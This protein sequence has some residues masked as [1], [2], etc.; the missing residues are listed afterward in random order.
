M[1]SMRWPY[2]TVDEPL[3]PVG[4]AKIK[5]VKKSLRKLGYRPGPADGLTGRKTSKA[6]KTLQKDRGL[7]IDG[8]PS[9]SLLAVLD[10]LI[11]KKMAVSDKTTAY[12][13]KETRNQPAKTYP[14][15]PKLYILSLGISKYRYPNLALAYAV[16]DTKDFSNTMITQKGVLYS[17]VVIKMMKNSDRD[18]VMK[19]LEWLERETTSRDVAMMFLAGHG[20]NDRNSNYYFLPAEGDPDGLKRTGIGYHELKN[21]LTGLPGNVVFFSWHLQHRRGDGATLSEYFS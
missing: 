6:I 4:R 3:R 21:T 19:G 13:K 14:F 17:V 15:K 5:Q 12:N 9:K 11:S 8:K 1:S 7:P 18:M 10:E 2:H 20:V 16:K